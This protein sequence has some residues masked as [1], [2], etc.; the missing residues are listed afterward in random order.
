MLPFDMHVFDDA[1]KGGPSLPER[2]M[3]LCRQYLQAADLTPVAAAQ[4]AAR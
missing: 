2:I 3:S 4:L 1:A